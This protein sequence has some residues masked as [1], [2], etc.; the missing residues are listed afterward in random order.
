MLSAGNL[1][2]YFFTGCTCCSLG[3]GLKR[4]YARL[5]FHRSIAHDHPHATEQSAR[6]A[7]PAALFWVRATGWNTSPEFVCFCPFVI[8]HNPG[9][10]SLLGPQ[11]GTSPHS[12]PAIAGTYDLQNTFGPSCSFLTAQHSCSL[13]FFVVLN[14]CREEFFASQLCEAMD[15]GFFQ[16]LDL[17]SPQFFPFFQTC[18]S[19]S[20][21]TRL[22]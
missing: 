7:F 1:S 3:W 18:L 13:W 19:R 14:L 22:E 8:F 12:I 5:F 10:V 20:W 2:H 16:T 15:G 11:L 9:C 21:K 6:T 17:P 4:M